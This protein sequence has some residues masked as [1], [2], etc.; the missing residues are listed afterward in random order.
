M[1]FEKVL[2]FIFYSDV[3]LYLILLFGVIYSIAW[4]AKPIWPFFL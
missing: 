4:P 1:N 2:K 3:I